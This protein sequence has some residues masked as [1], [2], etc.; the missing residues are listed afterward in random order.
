MP[1]SEHSETMMIKS[2]IVESEDTVD[3]AGSEVVWNEELMPIMVEP[4]AI[5]VPTAMEHD[6]GEEV[7]AS[8]RTPSEKVLRK[9]RGVGKVLGASLEG[10]EQRVLEL[11]MDIEARHKQKQDGAL[12]SRRP[13]SS[14][15]KCCRELKGLVSSVNYDAKNSREA[16]G[17]AKVQG[18][19]MMVNQ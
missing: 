16:K 9:L 18:G 8:G 17:K 14:G 10:Y 4:L 11:L 3:P 6:S 5:E 12:C 15:R 1:S 13:S 7:K 2:G 19:D